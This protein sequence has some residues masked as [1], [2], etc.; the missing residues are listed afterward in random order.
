MSGAGIVEYL[1][2]CPPYMVLKV[3]KSPFYSL[4]VLN[5]IRATT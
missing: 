4:N 5:A 3:M 1:A 2:D